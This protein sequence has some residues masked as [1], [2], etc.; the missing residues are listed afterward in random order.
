[1][2]ALGSVGIAVA[3]GFA[4]FVFEVLRNRTSDRPCEAFSENRKRL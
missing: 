1:M 2:P 3:V 4:G